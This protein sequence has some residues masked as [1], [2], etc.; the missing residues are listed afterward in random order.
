MLS[1]SPRKKAR[2]NVLITLGVLVVITLLLFR[3]EPLTPWQSTLTCLTSFFLVFFLW[4]ILIS[5][6]ALLPVTN[7]LDDPLQC[8]LEVYRTS[9]YLLLHMVGLHGPAVFVKDGKDNRT[10]EDAGRENWPGVVAVDFNSAVVLEERNPPPG[11]AGAFINVFTM[12]GQI[13]ML[14]DPRE[15]PRVRGAGIVF[16]RPRERIRGTIDLRKQFRGKAGISAYTREGIEVTSRVFSIFAV[17]QK[18]DVLTVTYVGERLPE[19]L[20]IITL[21]PSDHGDKWVN[22]ADISSVQDE[23]DEPDRAEIHAN[24]LNRGLPRFTEPTGDL[25]PDLSLYPWEFSPPVSDEPVFNARRVFSAV[26]AQASRKA[27]DPSSVT[28]LNWTE[29]P[30]HV[31]AGLFRELLSRVNYDEL[32]D[33]RG[34]GDFPL[35][36][37]KA[38]LRRAMR[39]NG[40]LAYRLV[41]PAFEGSFTAGTD[42]KGRDY[43]RSQ[44]LATHHRHPIELRNSKV[45]R[46]RGIRVIMSGFG[47]PTPV[48]S[49]V[50]QQRLDAWRASWEQEL[51]LTMADQDWAAMRERMRARSET[52]Q[53]MYYA[54]SR[55]FSQYEHADEAL[56]LR[57]LQALET[58][59]ADP[60]TRA[61]LPDYTIGLMR[62]VSALLLPPTE[63][64]VPPQ[65]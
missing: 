47:D 34:T 30:T 51:D 15:T 2:R 63:Q 65:R 18:P 27:D 6:Q 22:V 40:V 41:V 58:A 49:M 62:H 38:Q 53:E 35:P 29:L 46:D 42:Q 31:A 13:L 5:F 39:N 1:P 8:V 9:F 57:I 33:V 54:L 32:Y 28:V 23:L 17:G 64:Q 3:S 20:R 48:N 16:T 14:I 7:F 10:N 24:F 19:N 21:R 56:T 36:G 44:V 25:S 50:Y 4:V 11:M 45:L 52:Q 43:P 55:L 60:K 61:L 12:L 26:F 59:A 37:Y